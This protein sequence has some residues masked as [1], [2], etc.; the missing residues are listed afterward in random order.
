MVFVLF[1]FAGDVSINF[2]FLA[3]MIA[4][5]AAHIFYIISC[6]FIS[7]FPIKKILF[8]LLIYFVVFLIINLMFG[9]SIFNQD[10]LY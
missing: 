8:S 1:C 6:F 9:L 7:K 10:P 5:F 3:G 2:N 4:F